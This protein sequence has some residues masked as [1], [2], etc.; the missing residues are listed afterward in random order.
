[1]FFLIVKTKVL[2]DTELLRCRE[3]SWL[4]DETLF[5]LSQLKSVKH[6]NYFEMY[7]FFIQQV[8]N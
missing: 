5:K 6:G 2:A 4:I 7:N 3:M 1:M 8:V